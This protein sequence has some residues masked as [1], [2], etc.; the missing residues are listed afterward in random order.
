MRGVDCNNHC[1]EYLGAPKSV[2]MEEITM[3]EDQELNHSDKSYHF[4]T[5]NNLL[6]NLER[7]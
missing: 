1:Y 6:I 5:L 4:S 2:F 3:I 7:Q